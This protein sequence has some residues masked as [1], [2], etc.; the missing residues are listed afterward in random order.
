MPFSYS[1]NTIKKNILEMA[2][3]GDKIQLLG[4][5]CTKQ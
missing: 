5:L 1:I 3:Q 2:L 4:S